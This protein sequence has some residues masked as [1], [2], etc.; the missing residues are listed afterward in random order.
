MPCSYRGLA[1]VGERGCVTAVL[2][3]ATLVD[4]RDAP[5]LIL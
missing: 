3:T 2:I 5:L 4:R 1:W